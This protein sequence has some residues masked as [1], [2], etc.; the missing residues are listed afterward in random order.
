MKKI[1]LF[2]CFSPEIGG[3]GVCFRTQIAGLEG[4][5]LTWAHLGGGT[6][7]FSGCKTVCLGRPWV[8][9]PIV[10]DLLGSPF[11]WS[12]L[13]KGPARRL[14]AQL[15]DL[16]PDAFWILAM[17]EGVLVVPELHRMT[18]KPIH[19]SVQDDQEKG[20]FARMARYGWMSG[21]ASRPLAKALQTARSVDV[22][23]EG[24]RQYYEREL[25]LQSKVSHLVMTASVRSGEAQV[26][27][28]IWTVGHIGTLYDE[29]VGLRFGEALRVL[30]NKTGKR[31]QWHL[32]GLAPKFKKLRKQFGDLIEDHGNMPEEAAVDILCQCHAVYAMY[33]FKNSASVFRQTSFPTKLSTYL[34]AGRPIF[35]H[36]PG[37]STLADFVQKSELGHVC[38]TLD[39]AS[40]ANELMATCQMD[41]QA[42]RFHAAAKEVFGPKNIQ[43]IQD[44]LDALPYSPR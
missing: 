31:V 44:C 4:W 24:M 8:G 29:T 21:L 33:P 36:T 23:S 13:W 42:S 32:I 9:G 27:S 37:D 43:V 28:D 19:V 38:Q 25:G 2:S 15:A 1:V 10:K 14:A 34:Q 17:N 5:D 16:N 39:P 40:I 18:G 20:M 22:I 35:A 3:G 26:S 6:T 7:R 11:L 30:A 41:I 12:G